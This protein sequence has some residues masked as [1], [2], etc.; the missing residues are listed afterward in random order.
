MEAADSPQN[1]RLLHTK[2]HGVTSKKITIL[3]F[4][5]A[6]TPN[7]TIFIYEKYVSIRQ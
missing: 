7:P 1:V 4:T 6:Q 2:L 3:I 5:D